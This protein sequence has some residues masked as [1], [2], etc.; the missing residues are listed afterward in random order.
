VDG[1]HE[2]L[3]PGQ[4]WRTRW[5][6]QGFLSQPVAAGDGTWQ[7]GLALSSYGFAGAEQA[8]SGKA[9]V[10]TE[11]QR[12]TYHWDS[13]VEEWYVND[14]RGV[15]HGFT[16]AQR[17][18]GEE[19]TDQTDLFFTMKV[20]G[21]LRPDISGDA[22]AVRF[23]DA[24]GSAVVTYSGL[25]VWDADGKILPSHFA[26]AE[27][28]SFR[29][30]VDERGARYPLTV[31]PL[32]QQA[33][34]KASNTGA[35]DNFGWSVA[36]SGDLAVVGAPNEDSSTIGINN[37]PNESAG[38]AG[39]AYV[40]ERSGSN[41]SQL[42]FLKASNPTDQ[43]RFGSSVSISGNTIV[44]GAHGENAIRNNAG[45]A[46]VF[47]WNGFY[48]SQQAYLKASNPQAEAFFGFSVAI[49]GDTLVVGA[50]QESSSSTGV[51]STPNTSAGEAGAAY[52]FYRS[53]TSWTQQAYLKA[54]NTD[55]GDHFGNAVALSGETVVVGA[56][57]EDS[58]GSSPT[59]NGA[60][61]AGAAYVFTRA[62]TTWSFRAMLKGTSNAAGDTFGQSVALDGTT[63]VVGAPGTN[64]NGGVAHVRVGSGAG[65]I[66]QQELSDGSRDIEPSPASF[67]AWGHRVG[68][69]VAIS[70]EVLIVGAPKGSAGWFHS[71]ASGRLAY[72]YTRRGTAWTLQLALSGP[73]GNKSFGSSVALSDG[74]LLVGDPR[75][76]S[77]TTGV[78]STPNESAFD[79]GAAYTFPFVPARPS[80]TTQ[81]VTASSITSSG[82]R[83]N[84][85]V[86]PNFSST[87]VT[88]EYGESP[89][90]SL[91]EVE[92]PSTF[93][94]SGP[95]TASLTLSELLPGRTY[96]Y[97]ARAINGIND[98][99]LPT[100]SPFGFLTFT[101]AP[102]P[103][104]LITLSAT[105]ITS[106]AA[107]L[108]GLLSPNGRTTESWFA[109]DMAGSGRLTDHVI[110]PATPQNIPVEVMVDGL[111]PGTTY[112]FSL[113]GKQG[114]AFY[115][116]NT[117]TFT[118]LPDPLVGGLAEPLNVPVAGGGLYGSLIQPDGK[119]ILFGEFT[120]VYGTP[121]GRMARLQADG[122]LEGG[123][124]FNP[125]ANGDI[126]CAAVQADG[127]IMIGGNF[128]TLQP[129]GTGTIYNYSRL[130]RLFS[131]GTV[132]PSFANP[133]VNAY[134]LCMAVQPDGA[135][136]VGGDFNGS[137]MGA[138]RNRIARITPA[139]A[140]DTGFN[141]NASGPV[142]S[143]AHQPDGKVLLGGIFGQVS[144][145][146][147]A[148]VAR[149]DGT[150]GLAESGYTAA[151]DGAVYSI[152]LQRDGRA[153]VG[154]EFGAISGTARNRLARLNANGSLDLSFDPNVAGGNVFSIALQ[155]NQKMVLG[156]SF[157]SV[158]GTP[159]NK[160]A[161]VDT[162]GVLD[163]F[164]PN[165]TGGDVRSLA[166]RADGKLQLGGTFTAING[167]AAA[168]MSFAMLSNETAYQTLEKLSATEVH[169]SRGG[170]APE[171]LAVEFDQAALIG[172]T[173]TAIGSGT[174][175]DPLAGDWRLSGISP[176]LPLSGQIRA[177][178]RT[179]SGYLSGSTGIMESKVTYIHSLPV[180][181][182]VS[183]T[184]ITG[185]TALLTGT[186]D[187][188]TLK[189]TPAFKL[190]TTTAYTQPLRIADP[191]SVTGTATFTALVT[192]LTP[193]TAYVFRATA[194]NAGGRADGTDISFTTL[195]NLPAIYNTGAEVPATG[196]SYVATGRNV[197]FTLN[198]HP[199]P[200]TT[201]MV[202]NNTGSTPITG[203][204]ANLAQGQAVDLTHGA[205]TYPFVAHYYGGTGND[206][207]LLWR[208]TRAV[209]WGWNNLSQLGNG[210]GANQGAPV[211]V[212]GGLLDGKTLVS[213]SGGFQHSVA[214][215]VDGTIATWGDNLEGQLGNGDSVDRSSNVPTAVEQGFLP[216]GI[217]PVTV[218]AGGSHTLALFSNGKVYGWGDNEYGQ[219]GNGS[220][221]FDEN[222]PV[223]A[224]GALSGRRVIG[225]SAGEYHSLA[226][227][228]DGFV[229]AWGLGDSGQLGNGDTAN[230]KSPVAVDLTDVPPGE[231]IIAVAAGRWHSI[232]LTSGGK[233]FT[234]GNNQSGQLGDG[235]TSNQKHPILVP[236]LTATAIYGGGTYHSL[237]LRSDGKLVAWGTNIYGQLGTGDLVDSF[238]P[239]KV[240]AGW[241]SGQSLAMAIS[242]D[243]H[244]LATRSDGKLYAWGLGN[245]GR[246]GDND[247]GVH[248]Q[249]VQKPVDASVLDP[250]DRWQ[251]I[252]SGAGSQHSLAIIAVSLEPTA[253]TLPAFVVSDTEAILYGRVNAH[254]LPTNLSFDCGLDASTGSSIN[255]TPST[256]S[257]INPTVVSA[258]LTGLLPGRTY[259]YHVF[260]AQGAAYAL[261]D[262]LTFT[263]YTRLEMWRENWFGTK[264]N[265]GD[266]ANDADAD[267]DGINN[268][269]EFAFGL[270]PQQN[271]AGQL[272]QPIYFPDGIDYSFTEPNTHMGLTY[273]A[274]W[275]TT[276]APGSW[277]AIPDSA[278]APDHL[279]KL[280]TTGLPRVFVRLKVTA[281]TP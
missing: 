245:E 170:S 262:D 177:R 280:D 53:G 89:S 120:S 84:A 92:L 21:G 163:G 185:T 183:V 173:F 263:T 18:E 224:V 223:L 55:A 2:A 59:D 206:L 164:N 45:A 93:N 265:T 85:R 3:N 190:D 241:Q 36:I 127:K 88:F 211:A 249:P 168:R 58:N 213:M 162:T 57:Q 230:Q 122:T 114:S 259:S 159:R 196:S 256:L 271:S 124:G 6:G 179:A 8:V 116:G 37:A 70:G 201:L 239:T 180:V 174:R 99:L 86:F 134:V 65:W 81:P 61:D 107:T 217:H 237:A 74:I 113:W 27:A 109:Y 232:A 24:A 119:T 167:G 151:A 33:Y 160:V 172:T 246:L 19:R 216:P 95:A 202:V 129:R 138:T 64:K 132:D 9:T 154:G 194:E 72:V 11:G 100:V 7:W 110:Y 26:A 227:C 281:P 260:A 229:A 108:N 30:L 176:S 148:K 78:N 165:V 76:E 231:T 182:T 238:T 141:P 278:S 212:A 50:P 91:T 146:A 68:S 274:E 200:G 16:V 155:A 47:V 214:L 192:G 150:T 156:G 279:F 228:D 266:A 149:V 40:F 275:S 12:L 101:T 251:G 178:A 218:A 222:L 49:A 48:W 220:S 62:T 63:L 133:G 145:Q 87:S 117:V 195:A 142:Y 258:G 187:T 199:S 94:G 71:G 277:T 221:V 42:A 189:A 105:G 34:L 38:D 255:A 252:Y 144:G 157:T 123:L 35:H 51:N 104:T 225:I 240:S 153:L 125:G 44:V 25:K 17:P 247:I 90:G 186:V 254:G 102:G 75:E 97:R 188:S 98:A 242:G 128:T 135:V 82:A 267:R 136:L 193:G 257:G 261:G 197:T 253:T 111:L 143:I 210:N 14:G 161:R 54:S 15:E 115:V 215:C 140:L 244:N 234:W 269:L 126:I 250:G 103:P 243:E 79:A 52:V 73:S 233:V 248:T 31:D 13:T 66:L 276:L 5:D 20:R 39:A 46:Y 131:D 121:H 22:Q 205:F 69:S 137:F 152:A 204:F 203:T 80:I 139:G 198:Y 270:D 226:V 169:W 272:P 236:D 207:V 130:A 118:T 184:G 23:L 166:L 106:T 56:P 268:L 32:A 60:T 175:V 10:R 181:T 264:D 208:N 41:W 158:G 147:H 219:L 77:S 67:G 1:G 171:V 96:R 273:G 28:D 4:G 29:L 191:A 43:D 112:T 83:V 235:N 209:T